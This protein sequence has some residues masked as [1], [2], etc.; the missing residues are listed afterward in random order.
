M[1]QL[2]KFEFGFVL[3]VTWLQ[4]F[5]QIMRHHRSYDVSETL[6][7]LHLFSQ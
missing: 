1:K 4:S 2:K 5:Y 6:N 3:F 7:V